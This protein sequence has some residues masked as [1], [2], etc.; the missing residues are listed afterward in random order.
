MG[1]RARFPH[2]SGFDLGILLMS[3]FLGFDL[4][5]SRNLT[6]ALGISWK[7]K[8]FNN[9]NNNNNNNNMFKQDDHFSYKNCYQY[10]SCI[11][12]NE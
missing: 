11:K 9:N 1:V 5:N 2:Y 4:G 8:L 6:L 7:D 3:A 12:I 10:G